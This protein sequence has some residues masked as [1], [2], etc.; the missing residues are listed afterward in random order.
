MADF[1]SGFQI[2]QLF[3]SLFIYPLK[4]SILSE[5]WCLSQIE[6]WSWE[7]WPGII[8]WMGT[9]P[10]KPFGWRMVIQWSST[11]RLPP[12]PFCRTPGGVIKPAG[13]PRVWLGRRFLLPGRNVQVRQWEG[14][15]NS[16]SHDGSMG[17][18][19]LPNIQITEITIQINHPCR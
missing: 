2:K 15:R 6:E 19:Y 13:E 14:V 5:N 10:T 11:T 12:Q 7:S 16:Y 17:L 1:S 9:H 4:T 8:C 18:V 3:L